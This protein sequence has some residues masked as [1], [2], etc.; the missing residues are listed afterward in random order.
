MRQHPVSPNDEV[1]RR[2]VA[3]SLNEAGL[4]QSSTSP[5]LTED[6]PRDRSNRLLDGAPRPLLGT[7]GLDDE[8]SF[9]LGI[10][11]LQGR[12]KSRSDQR[13]DAR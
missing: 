12:R 13:V 4:F 10:N 7:Y 1:E 3:V 8:L 2:G 5:W 11:W 9:R 6:A